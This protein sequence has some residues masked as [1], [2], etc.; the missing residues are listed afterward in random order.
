MNYSKKG[1]ELT[2]GFE[3]C[4]LTAYWDYAGKVLTIGY[5]HTGV[6]VCEGLT[7]T[8]EQADAALLNDVHW[9]E[10]T[11]NALVRVRLTQEEFD[12]LVDFTFNVGASNFLHSTLLTKLNQ[13]DYNGA[14]LEFDNWRFSH[15]KEMAGLLR[16]RQAETDLFNGT[17]Q[18]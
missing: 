14:A 11:V 16:R 15:G 13:A 5:G 2:K 17:A 9:C 3:Q 1:S 6:E 18:G 12:A 10:R 7:W 8:Q 4:R